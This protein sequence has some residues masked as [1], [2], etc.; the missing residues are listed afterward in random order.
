M[1]SISTQLLH[2]GIPGLDAL[3]AAS[4]PLYQTATFELDEDLSGEYDYSRSENPTRDVL[5]AQ[6][7]RLDGAEKALAYNTG[8]AA[9]FGVLDLIQDRKRILVATDIYGGTNRLLRLEG[10][11]RGWDVQRF[12]PEDPASLKALLTDQVGLVLLETPSNPGLTCAD[13]RALADVLADH[14]ALLAVDNTMLGPVLQRPLELGADLAIQSATKSLCGHSDLTAG[15][16]SAN[17]PELLER[18]SY[19]RNALGLAL[20][21][22]DSWLLHRSL[23]TL[24]LRVRQATSN[25]DNLADELR[26]W[27]VPLQVLRPHD[28]VQGLPIPCSVI[29]VR[30]GDA[31]TARQW[32][33]NTK[34][35][36]STVSFGG[37]ASS[38][39]IPALMSHASATDA[40]RAAAGVTNDLVRI[41]VG[42]EDPVD[43]AQDLRASYPRTRLKTLSR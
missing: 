37:A 32:V 12:Q 3:R 40:E 31:E 39:S 41:S 4:P 5:E 21:P 24:D 9:V 6:L 25:A 19:R 2:G 22:F 23:L 28:P 8:I 7:A 15:V 16:I 30:V 1:S 20:A 34:L 36:R 42:I 18:L 38:M 29:S 17:N 35:F 10:P 13:I 27:D 14:P 11:Q 33:R 26:S 43:L